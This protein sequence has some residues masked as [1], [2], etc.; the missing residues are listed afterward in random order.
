[1]ENKEFL[2]SEEWRK[3][4]ENFGRKTYRITGEN[5]SASIIE[6]KLP[7]VGKYLYIPRRSIFSEQ[8]FNELFKLAK[9]NKAGWIRFDAEDSRILDLIRENWQVVKSPHDMQPR[10]NFVIDITKPEEELLNEMKSK[11]RY[12]INLAQKK[13]VLVHSSQFTVN[14]KSCIDEFIRLV[15]ATAERKGIKFHVED[16]YRKMVETIP[17]NMLKLY[18]AE[19]NGKIIATN[20]VVFYGKTAIYLHGATDDEYRNVMAPYLLQW[21]AILDAKKAGCERYDFGGVKAG[22]NNNWSGITK[23]KLGFSMNT[24]PVESLGSYDIVVSPV[25]YWAYRGLQKIKQHMSF[26]T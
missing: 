26:R 7:I 2:Q 19:Y 9:E 5:F 14:D 15:K 17:E 11:T 3:F 13:G 6:H 25:R 23:F 8:C 24:K 21:Q 20:L 4:Q 16:Y 12:N 18:C 22:S 10:E 1:M